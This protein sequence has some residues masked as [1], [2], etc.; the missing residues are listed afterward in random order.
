MK[1]IVSLGLMALLSMSYLAA[2]IVQDNELAIVYYLPQ[3][4]LTFQIEYE[5]EILQR[6]PFA[7]YAKQYL[8]ATDII[9]EDATHFRLLA[10]K[11]YTNA[12]ADPGRAYKVLAEKGLP[13]QLLSLT[14]QGTLYGFNVEPQKSTPPSKSRKDVERTAQEAQVMPLLEEHLVGK[15]VAQSAQGAA[16]L[17]YRLRETR[18]Y[19][20]GGEVDHAPA[21]GK[22][23]ELVLNELEK[24]ERELT[25]LFI[26]HREVKKHSKT[27]TYTPVKS[28]E[29]ELAFFSEKEGLTT[30]GNGEPIM[31][32]IAARR[33][34]K[35]SSYAVADKKAPAPSPIF[36]NLPGSA[37]YKV[38][39]LNEVLDEQQVA[40]AQFGVAVPLARDLFTGSSLPHIIFNT[41]T[42]NIRSI[43]Q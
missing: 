26:G 34:M 41:K 8:G 12:V 1:K 33:Q 27:I 15:S 31:L 21:D 20:L 6:G 30:A 18:L 29:V 4:Q 3:T 32:N 28:E 43:T 35:G 36:Y 10:V 16:K 22:A 7:D 14:S 38:V 37:T 19:I 5:E 40:I 39:Y 11:S 9:T 24:Q 17:I 25:E 42:G 2:Q 13:L 23:M